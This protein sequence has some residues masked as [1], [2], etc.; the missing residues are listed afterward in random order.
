MPEG[1]TLTTLSRILTS[2]AHHCDSSS[3]WTCRLWLQ[4]HQRSDSFDGSSSVRA[5]DVVVS[6]PVALS[7][8]HLVL[9][10]AGAFEVFRP[11][12]ADSQRAAPF[13]GL[14]VLA[15]GPSIALTVQ[16]TC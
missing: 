5:R 2:F 6:S 13:M 14:S 8:S 10:S 3:E 9:G 16:Q 1:G 11:G 4:T 12:L 15:A 7:E